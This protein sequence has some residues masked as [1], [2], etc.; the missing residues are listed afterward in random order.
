MR[1]ARGLWPVC[2]PNQA[3]ER[4]SGRHAGRLTPVDLGFWVGAGEG[5][6]TLMTSLEGWSSAIELRP[7][8]WRPISRPGEHRQSTRTEGSAPNHSSQRPVSAPR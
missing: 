8:A 3:P 5:N 1:D 2:G 6:R 7:R 4:R